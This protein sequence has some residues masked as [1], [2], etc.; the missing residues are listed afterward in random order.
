MTLSAPSEIDSMVAPADEGR[1]VI[2]ATFTADDVEAPLSHLLNIVGLSLTASIAPYNQVFQELLTPGSSFARNPQGVNVLLLRLADSIRDL[3]AGVDPVVHIEKYVTE[4]QEAIVSYHHRIRTPTVVGILRASPDNEGQLSSV[5]EDLGLRL[6]ESISKLNGFS[7]LDSAEIHRHFE[8]QHFDA[9]SDTLAHIP[10]AAEYF[11]ALAIAVGRRVN[12]LKMAPKK[13]LVLDCDNTIWGG[14]VGEDGVDGLRLEEP[15]QSVQQF[16]LTAQSRG[17]LLCLASKNEDQ[18]V[19]SVFDRRPDMILQAHHIVAHRINWEDKSANLRSLA[20]QLNLGLDSFVFLDDNPVECGLM[21]EQLPQVTTLRLPEPDRIKDFLDNLWVFDRSSVTAEDARRTE[22]YLENAAR[23]KFESETR[24]IGDFIASLQ[25]TVKI[26]APDETQWARAAQL[27]QRTNQ[28]NFT[29]VRRSE[30]ELRLLVER[31]AFVRA[32]HAQD[33]FGDYGLVGVVIARAIDTTLD[34]DSFLLSC[35]VLGRGIEHR[36][37]SYL[38]TLATELGLTSVRI[39]YLPTEKNTPAR[40]FANSIAIDYRD[41]DDEKCEYTIPASLAAEI[42]HRPGEDAIEVIEARKN[43]GAKSVVTTSPRTRRTGDFE[44]IGIELH[45][46]ESLLESMRSMQVME[47]RDNV[48]AVQPVG[49]TEVRLLAI[50]ETLLNVTGLGVESD[51]FQA[52]GTSLLTVRLFA[53]VERAF[54][55]RLPLTLILT[56][57]TVR[58]LSRQ[59]ESQGHVT[60]PGLVVLRNGGPRRLFLVHDGDGETLLYRTLAQL[61]P[62]NVSVFGIQPRQQKGI[63]LIHTTIEEMAA[64]YVKDVFAMQPQGPYLLGGLCAGGLIAYEMAR[65]LQTQSGTVNCILLLDAA[66]PQAMKREGLINS[67]RRSRLS[68]AITQARSGRN[69]IAATFAMGSA[70]GRKISGALRY[71]VARRL[72]AASVKL[73]SRVLQRVLAKHQSWPTVLPSLS[74]REIYNLAEKDYRPTLNPVSTVLFR[75]SHGTGND[76]PYVE[77]FEDPA[78]G[79]AAVAQNLTV[80]DVEGGH[81]SMLQEPHVTKLA[82]TLG[83]YVAR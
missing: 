16:A 28:F 73:R 75:A 14:V 17:V 9:E 2:A 24:D 13:V 52:G 62:S 18:D 69:A 48:S 41:G 49:D 81:S 79:W 15:F 44:R 31:G 64:C 55:V 42:Q 1:V 8:G 38:G 6:R 27:T 45:K 32:I 22:M 35:R 12:M 33:R 19:W 23:D 34:V 57:P 7:I 25:M 76:R 39:S 66:T 10:Y 3:P 70:I 30:A 47:H 54:N 74:F 53:E 29:T 71:E 4:L 56:A 68:D 46:A 60:S 67:E 11:S 72:Q 82:S 77:I 36:I 37:V 78:L 5:I 43:D 51:F 65:Q 63:P 58:L 80:V 26:A 59:I 40:A 21:R 61:L 20:R 50:W 83:K